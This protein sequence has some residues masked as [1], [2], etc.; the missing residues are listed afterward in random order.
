MKALVFDFLCIVL[1]FVLYTILNIA[2]CIVLYTILNI[3][4][5]VVI[6]NI[7][8]MIKIDRKTESLKAGERHPEE[9]QTSLIPPPS[10]RSFQI[11]EIILH[12]GFRFI[13]L[14]FILFFYFIFSFLPSSPIPYMR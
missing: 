11:P 14:F 3:A 1:H 13:Q 10:P 8:S 4:L 2:P 6:I 9:I 12:L 7:I 5:H